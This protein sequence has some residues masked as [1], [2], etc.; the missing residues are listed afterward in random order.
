MSGRYGLLS[1]EHYDC[2]L[3][4]KSLDKGLNYVLENRAYKVGLVDSV[5]IPTESAKAD[6][7]HGA[8]F[9]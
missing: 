2:S 3:V 7:L 1:G 8:Q 6:D 5:C 9:R 4:V